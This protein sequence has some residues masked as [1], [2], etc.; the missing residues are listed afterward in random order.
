M[1]RPQKTLKKTSVKYTIHWPIQKSS[2]MHSD[3]L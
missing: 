3:R 2:R 1:F